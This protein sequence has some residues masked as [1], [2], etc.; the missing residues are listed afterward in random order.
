M[1]RY[2][3][4]LGRIVSRRYATRPHSTISR[5]VRIDHEGESGPLRHLVAHGRMESRPYTTRPHPT[6]DKV[7]RID[8]AGEFGANRIYA[9]Q[10]AVLGNTSVGPVIDVRSMMVM[11]QYY[12]NY[13]SSHLF[14][15]TCGSRRKS[16]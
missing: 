3:G 10:L 8:H 1:S 7:I 16:I 5:V 4:A 13:V 14:Y 9:G 2:L 15:S 11:M 6:I 12:Y